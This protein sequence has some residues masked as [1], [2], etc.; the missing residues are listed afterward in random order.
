M[1]F[2]EKYR[3]ETIVYFGWN[4]SSQTEELLPEIEMSLEKSFSELRCRKVLLH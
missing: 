3:P 1:V 4:Y 2:Q